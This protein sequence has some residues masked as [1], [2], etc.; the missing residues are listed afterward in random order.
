M[1]ATRDVIGTHVH[2]GR[3]CVV[4]QANPKA[5]TVALLVVLQQDFDLW[6]TE[7]RFCFL[8]LFL[9]FDPLLAFM[10][11]QAIARHEHAR[12]GETR[13]DYSRASTRID[14]NYRER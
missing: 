6:P 3:I 13:K 4:H 8:Q 5:L 12:Y 1:R 11:P 7:L 2:S 14:R 9:N 10:C